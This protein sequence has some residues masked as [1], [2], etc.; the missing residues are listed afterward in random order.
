MKCQDLQALDSMYEPPPP[1]WRRCWTALQRCVP[2]FSTSP[3]KSTLTRGSSIWGGSAADLDVLETAQ[4]V[5]HVHALKRPLHVLVA[6]RAGA[7][8]RGH[9]ASRLHNGRC[10][11]AGACV[12]AQHS[13]LQRVRRGRSQRSAPSRRSEPQR[14]RKDSPCSLP[15]AAQTLASA[16]AR[17]HAAG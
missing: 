5:R 11:R 15:A 8:A 3:S 1:L 7:G 12:L 6:V 14:P 9:G 4:E 13:R 17:S 2:C 10:T 16:A